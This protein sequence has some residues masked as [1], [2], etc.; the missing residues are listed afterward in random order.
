VRTAEGEVVIELPQVRN[1]QEPYRSKVKEFF[2]G[3]TD[4][5]ERLTA[6]MYARGLS[7]RDSEDALMELTGDVVLSKSSISKVTD[8]LWEE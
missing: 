3:N 1:T 6:E 8:I 4:C 2:R 5:L 7:T